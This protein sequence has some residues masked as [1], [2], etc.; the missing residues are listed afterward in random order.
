MMSR[1]GT[2]HSDLDTLPEAAVPV[3]PADTDRTWAGLDIAAVAAAE[4]ARTDSRS[5]HSALAPDIGCT[6]PGSLVAW[7]A[8]AAGMAAG[9][10]T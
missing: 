5:L 2:S 1:A 10:K 6:G 8:A 4:V 7:V 3:H 9:N